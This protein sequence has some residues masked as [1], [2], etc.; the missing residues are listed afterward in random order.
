MRISDSGLYVPT[1]ASRSKPAQEQLTT[2]T[3]GSQTNTQ[4]MLERDQSASGLASNL[5][6]LQTGVYSTKDAAE[7]ALKRSDLR[8]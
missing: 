1:Y 4:R 8:A 6:Q 2:T 3:A 5:W 7:A